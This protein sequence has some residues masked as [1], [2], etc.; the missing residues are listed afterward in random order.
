MIESITKDVFKNVT[1]GLFEKDKTLFAFLIA[2][3]INK[4]AKVISEDSWTLFTRGPVILE[5]AM[6]KPNPSKTLFS[7]KAWELAEYLEAAFPKY[8]GITASFCNKTKQW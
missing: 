2:S 7:P 6:S 1:R 3:S 5:N 8:T 4:N